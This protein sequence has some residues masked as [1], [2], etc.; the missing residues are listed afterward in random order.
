MFRV[1]GACSG[2]WHRRQFQGISRELCAGVKAKKLVR[3]IDRFYGRANAAAWGDKV[4]FKQ[5]EAFYWLSKLHSF[6]RVADHIGLTQPAVS[7]RISGLE[8]SFGV[9]LIDR[10]E[11]LFTLTEQGQE[12]AEFAET[13]LN[14]SEQLATRMKH[15]QKRRL[16]I[17]MVGMVTTTWGRT[18]RRKIQTERPGELVDFVSGGNV[19]LN[20]QIRSGALD[21]AFVT[22][23]AGLPQVANS[24]SVHYSV[25]WVARPDVVGNITRPLTPDE[26]REF[27]LVLYP[28]GSPLYRPVAELIEETRRRPNARHTGNSLGMICDMVRAGYGVSAVPLVALEREL[29]TGLLVEV[30]ATVKLAPMDVRCVH[31][32]KARRVQAEAILALARTAAIEWCAAHPRYMTFSDG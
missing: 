25:G 20:P 19:E 22:G 7:A 14:L 24:F 11:A 2:Q 26:I 32:N 8:D 12:V 6:Q 28:R 29:A 15:G 16:S 9:P 17:G 31:I 13:F 4:N 21:L 10:N 18:L 23:E 3:A 27:P 30:P 5:L 1:F